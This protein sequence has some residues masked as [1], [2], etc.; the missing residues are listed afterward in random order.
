MADWKDNK[1]AGPWDFIEQSDKWGYLNNP[2]WSKQQNAIDFCED[3]DLTLDLADQHKPCGHWHKDEITEETFPA[4]KWVA[5]MQQSGTPYIYVYDI[6]Q[7]AVIRIDTSEIPV[8]VS[9]R[10]EL[11]SAYAL[12]YDMGWGNPGAQRGGYCMNKDATRIWYLFTESDGDRIDAE[13]IE[14]DISRTIMRKV[15]STHF[16]NLMAPGP[17]PATRER[18]NDGCSDDIHTYWCTNLVAGRIIKIRNSDHS[19]VDDHYFNYPIEACGTGAYDEPIATID[20]NKYN[21]K[22][23]WVYCRDHLGCIPIY[24]ACRHLI[25]A[26]PDL[27]A[28]IEEIICGSG[29]GAPGWQNMIRIYSNYILHHRSY[30]YF[31]GPLMKRDLGLSKEDTVAGSAFWQ[32]A[33][34]KDHYA[35]LADRPTSGAN[36]ATYWGRWDDQLGG[37]VWQEGKAYHR[38]AIEQ[39]HLQNILGVKKGKVFTLMHVH[40]LTHPGYLY[41]IDFSNMEEISNLDISYYAGQIY[42]PGGYDWDWTS[43]SAMNQQTGV[44]AIFRYHNLEERNY[45]GCFN[46]DSSLGLLCDVPLYSIKHGSGQGMSNEP[47]I[48]VMPGD[49]APESAGPMPPIPSGPGGT[50]CTGQT[51]KLSQSL[52]SVSMTEGSDAINRNIRVTDNCNVSLAFQVEEVNNNNYITWIS[53]PM[54]DDT[55]NGALNIK[56]N[57]VSMSAGSYAGS[58]VISTNLGN[59]TLNI[60]LIVTSSPAHGE[61][62]GITLISGDTYRRFD[63]RA[64]EVKLFKFRCTCG[65]DLLD[66][67]TCV[68]EVMSHYGNQGGKLHYIIK[69]VGQN[70][71]DPPP[72]DADYAA[73]K[74]FIAGDPWK[75]KGIYNDMYYYFTNTLSKRWMINLDSLV[76]DGC[77]Y[78]WVKNYGAISLN[79]CFVHF[80]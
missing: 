26:N 24:N 43:V 77:W 12:D 17:A 14:V 47:Q 36:Y 65:P 1:G 5:A 69:Y 27:V 8:F 29:L 78:F 25:R 19:I 68:A 37:N 2:R 66:T 40:S 20:Y 35:T 4:G 33:C 67:L 74:S 46:A 6:V 75:S 51:P 34:I 72:N 54:V 39:E 16:T 10:L 50:P 23:Y 18:I 58:I 7:K 55:G 76:T 57:T 32:W 48:W 21:E 52:I 41:C 73:I 15:K 62:S 22:L 53:S 59:L 3:H 61:A 9:D 28:D 45:V 60:N 70:W 11:D 80:R 31:A 64:G 56:F 49:E 30:H 71:E 63:F 44:I 38:F 42:P 79:G 13:L